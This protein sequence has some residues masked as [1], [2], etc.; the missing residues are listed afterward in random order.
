[1]YIPFGENISEQF[2]SWEGRGRGWLLWD[3][4]VELEPPFKPF[5]GYAK[6]QNNAPTNTGLFESFFKSVGVVS[7]DQDINRNFVSDDEEYIQPKR[8]DGQT[9]YH[10]IQI[11][12][13]KG[14]RFSGEEAES[15]L[16]L[17]S[18]SKYPIAFEIIGT[19]LR[20]VCQYVCRS[21]D[22]NQLRNQLKTFFPNAFLQE[23]KEVLN[24]AIVQ[25][26]NSAIYG[27][28]LAEE[29]MRPIKTYKSFSL[30]PLIAL[31][32]LMD[33]LR[34]GEVCAMQVLF[35]GVEKPW[36]ESI[37]K[38]VMN[39]KGESYFSDA[40]DMAQLT[41]KKI[42]KPLFAVVVNTFVQGLDDRKVLELGIN[43]GTAF[44]T[45]KDPSSNAFIPITHDDYPFETRYE[46]F[47]LRQT[48][49]S[50]MILNSE[51]LV[52]LV[53]F[54][55]SFNSTKIY[56]EPKKSKA[57]PA[58]ALGHDF[59]LG[60]NVCGD[61]GTK[62]SL[63]ATQ[64][65]KHLHVIG[66]TGSGKSTLLENLIIQDI[67]SGKGCAVLDP[68]GDLI[69]SIIE[70]I[71]E[72]R[73]KD[74]VLV[75]P[76]DAEF[77]VGINI[78][79][80]Y[81]EIEKDV[82]SSDLV[83]IF[84]RY[85]TGWGAQMSAVL[86]NA[87]AAFIESKAG[88]TLI[89]LKRFLVD[90][91]FRTEFLKTVTEPSIV[92]YWQKEYP[93]LRTNSIGPILT[94][95][96][97]FLRPKLIRNMVA[98]RDGLNFDEIVNS[99]KILLIKLSQGLIGIENSNL[100]G[101]LILSKIHQVAIARQLIR[102]EDRKPFFVYVDECQYFLSPSME[103]ILSGGRKFSL[104]LTL[105]HQDLLQLS[106]SDVDLANSITNAGTRICFKVGEVDSRKLADG[107]TF[108]D[109]KN[110]QN[111]ET[112]E[113]I[114]KIDKPDN[115]FNLSVFNNPNIDSEIGKRRRREITN[116]SRDK[117]S[118]PKAEIEELIARF[119]YQSETLKEEKPEPVQ[120]VPKPIKQE[121]PVEKETVKE[122]VSDQV[123]QNLVEA[124]KGPKMPPVKKEETE[125]RYFQNFIKRIAESFG[126][127]ATIEEAIPNGK[128]DVGLIRNN[129]KIAVEIS[130]TTSD[131][132]ELQNVKKCLKAG[133]N[134]VIV[135]PTEKKNIEKI[136]KTVQA[137]IDLVD[138]Q[139]VFVF[140]PGEIQDYL[141]NVI[142]K[143]STSEETVKGY[144]V[145]VNFEELSEEDKKNKR[146]AIS[147]IVYDSIKRTKKE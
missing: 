81:S 55:H 69:D 121:K 67:K 5:K 125:H 112:G 103:S 145:K 70:H 146:D 135:C 122:F 130:S 139:R 138:I 64:R 97:S 101:S 96:D 16:T 32:G 123:S 79:K 8:L 41:K 117:Y 68:H 78:L 53:H 48:H 51:E 13:P 109:S 88:G 110:L 76:S 28:G 47:K 85:T 137:N 106:R 3:Y 18:Y 45:F 116:L 141:L 92:Y 42:S 119:Y 62:V 104:G 84:Q 15:F 40:P 87:V 23:E 26:R 99:N 89:D 71:P 91:A 129:L 75:D 118:K 1:M 131:A 94:R 24:K 57:A 126:F 52:S 114:V 80:A 65:L 90:K 30:D 134:F 49:L 63:S 120:S 43:V 95:L 20:I 136:R 74:I 128:V 83:S 105:S 11:S 9:G 113:A 102:E 12:F 35:K 50:G 54:P 132:H 19:K 58:I 100:L 31:L 107:F 6:G 39:H 133:Y 93:L 56:S 140:E 22:A 142:A 27:I 72:N 34:D 25:E 98:Q 4:P 21:A 44:S 82:L 124:I 10:E 38:A 14:E 127:K 115:D 143:E 147:K 108:F 33:N 61:S 77:P 36:S 29:F 17:L 73:C 2:Y 86:A 60:E 59:I 144:R 37:V 66:V 111:L 7:S 46:D